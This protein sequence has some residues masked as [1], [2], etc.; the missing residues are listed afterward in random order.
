M[1]LHDV[2]AMIITT[3]L[4]FGNETQIEMGMGG[5]LHDIG[6]SLIKSEIINKKSKTY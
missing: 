4:G 6:K 3:R 2:F 1:G 5:M